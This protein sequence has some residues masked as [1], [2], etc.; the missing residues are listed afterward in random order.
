MPAD[1]VVGG[2]DGEVCRINN[3]DEAMGERMFGVKARCNLGSILHFSERTTFRLKCNFT[4]Y[5]FSPGIMYTRC[6]NRKTDRKTFPMSSF[7]TIL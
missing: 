1:H 5:G 6:L 2:R 3:E 7:E 4:E